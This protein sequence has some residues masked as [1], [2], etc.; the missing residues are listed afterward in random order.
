MPLPFKSYLMALP[1]LCFVIF[2]YIW[3]VLYMHVYLYKLLRI[4]GVPFILFHM[5]SIYVKC[6][7]VSVLFAQQSITWVI[8]FQINNFFLTS[9]SAFSQIA[10]SHVVNALVEKALKHLH[11]WKLGKKSLPDE[12]KLKRYHYLGRKYNTFHFGEKRKE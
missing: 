10:Q 6:F 8:I 3:F 12:K 7:I 1:R 5:S 4:L 11:I 2:C 9:W